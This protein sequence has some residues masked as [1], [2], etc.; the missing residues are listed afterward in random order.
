MNGIICINKPSGWTSFDVVA[1]VRGITQT[2]KVGHAGTLD[3]MAT[4]VLPL[5]LGTATKVC[6]IMPNSDKGYLA[7]FRLGI[8]TDTLDITGTVLK[9]EPSHASREQ[10]EQVLDEFRGTISQL[11]PMYSAVQVN[12]R[13]L[14]DIARSGE[15]VERRPR[16]VTVSRLMLRDFDEQTQEGELE[17]LCS[18]GTYIRSLCSDIGDKLG[19]GAVLTALIRHCSGDFTLQ[20]CL[21]LEELQ[22]AAD[23]GELEH[24][25]L[26]VEKVFECFPAIYLNTTQ[27]AKFQNG[28]KLDLN[29]VRFQNAEGLHRVFDQNKAFLG[30]ASLNLKEMELKIE[31]MFKR[32]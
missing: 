12:G 16:Q 17:V 32:D 8:T 18:K 14:Y 3:P 29:R 21:T 31:K 7:K 26:P 25:L 27:A 19:C 10:L 30:L 28:V 5:F 2:R 24:H 9:N 20:D 23:R 1:K 6:D 13:R 4:G 11:P 15:T 22:Q